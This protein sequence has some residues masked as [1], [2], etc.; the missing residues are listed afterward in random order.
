MRVLFASVIGRR[1]TLPPPRILAALIAG[2]FLLYTVVGACI[3][4]LWQHR[5]GVPLTGAGFGYGPLIDALDQTG[6]Y[7]VVDVHYPGVAFSA[8]RLPLIPYALMALREIVGDD[9]AWIGLAKALLFNS[10]LAATAWIVLRR[11][12]FLTVA[13][14]LLL[15]SPLTLP[16]WNLIL[17]EI[18]VEEAY[19]IPLLG[20]LTVL[21]WFEI[22]PIRQRPSAIAG[23]ILIC[24]CL[25]WIKHS[26][27]YWAMA[28]PVFLGLR[29]R[30]WRLGGIALAVVASSLT[31]LAS[32][33]LQV[34]GRFTT[35]SSWEGW[36][37]YK[38]NNPATRQTYP[39]HSLDI[40]DYTGGVQA[41]RPLRDEWDH[42]TYFK[43]KA[44]AFIRENPGEFAVNCL[45]KAWVF[46]FEIRRTGRSLGQE[47]DASALRLVQSG[48]LA[49]YRLLF[50]IAVALAVRAVLLPTESLAWRSVPLSFLLLIVLYAGFHVVG[51]A[52]ERHV[53]PL[54]LPTIL[55]LAWHTGPGRD[56]RIVSATASRIPTVSFTST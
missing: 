10:L 12:P 40:L 15:A 53:M 52:Y 55:Y 18:S 29:T 39:Y 20:L 4:A 48:A 8:H 2:G 26:M 43:D 24:A 22:T 7:R 49:V 46:F 51:F 32:F 41:D 37:L 19:L 31:A 42:N 17:F 36:N 23:V 21:L 25:P 9:L 1:L 3:A 50:W 47:D 33:N 16:F 28:A 54:V 5:A 27:P 56:G 35:Q 11:T 14:L 34:S 45:R 6:T 44:W 13:Q 30:S 38:G